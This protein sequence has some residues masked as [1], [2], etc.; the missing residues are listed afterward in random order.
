VR[1]TLLVVDDDPQIAELIRDMMGGLPVKVLSATGAEEARERIGRGDIDLLLLE[2][3]LARGGG[4]WLFAAARRERPAMPVLM[5][6]A[7][8][9]EGERERVLAGG[10]IE[11]WEKPFG[12]ADVQ[13]RILRWALLALDAR[14]GRGRRNGNGDGFTVDG[15]VV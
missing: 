7:S 9:E 6:S 4:E 11:T 15:N 5:M 14:A 13:R 10:A 12:M 1:A 8:W 3:H 2:P